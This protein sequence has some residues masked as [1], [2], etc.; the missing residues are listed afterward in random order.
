MNDLGEGVDII[1]GEQRG[2]EKQV[3]GG[4]DRSRSQGEVEIRMVEQEE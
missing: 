2:F 4:R 3:V 1:K